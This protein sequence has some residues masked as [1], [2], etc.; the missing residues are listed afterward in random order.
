MRTVSGIVVI[1]SDPP[2]AEVLQKGAV[3]GRTPFTNR[4]DVARQELAVRHSTL[5][6]QSFVVD[7]QENK[8]VTKE[9]RF[10][11]GRVQLTSEPAGA[12]VFVD[13]KK[14]GVTTYDN[15]LV[16]PGKPVTYEVR[17]EKLGKMLS[18]TL[19]L[20]VADGQTLKTNVV[21]TSGTGVVVLTGNLPGAKVHWQAKAG[22]QLLGETGPAPF[23]SK[24]IDKGLQKLV[25][26]HL[27]LGA[28]E[29]AVQVKADA[30][31]PV[32]VVFAYGSVVVRAE[33][34]NVGA[35]VF[36]GDE[37]LGPA[38][39][40]VKMIKAGPVK[41]RVQAEDYAPVLL[42]GEVLAGKTAELVAKL[43]LGQ[44]TLEL[45][46]DMEGAEAFLDNQPIGKLPLKSLVGAGK[47][48]L[49]VK[50]QNGEPRTED[51]RLKR[52]ATE[53]R[54]F[55]FG[56][57]LEV[58]SDVEGAEAFLDGKPLGK[59]PLKQ[60]IVAGAH[61]L[62]VKCQGKEPQKE[63]VKLEPGKVLQREFFFEMLRSSCGMELL[64]VPGVPGAAGGCWVGKYE[65]TQEEY[66]KVMGTNPSPDNAKNPRKPVVRVSHK[67]AVEFCRKL[68][69]KD[70]GKG[71]RY[72]LPT[73][74]QWEYLTADARL[75]D[76]VT[77]W[78]LPQKRE[79]PEVVG[80]T[81]KRNKFGLFDTRGNA[82]EWCD[83][84]SNA[85]KKPL[86]GAGYE[87]LNDKT[88]EKKYQFLRPD[89]AECGSGGFRC[90]ALPAK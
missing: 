28:L 50:C 85:N 21:L 12:E 9:V 64:R 63:P 8:T 44:G 49:V 89:G 4:M 5:G 72:A 3:L 77:S 78:G 25:A 55:R 34:A 69:E 45:T 17:Q 88:L 70:A 65:V 13:G 2:D 81:G 14:A 47:H 30:E 40:Q 75:E 36:A 24:P 38:P 1:Q 15:P 20:Q 90:V 6:E 74:E 82:W 66:E 18:E 59:L 62:E 11:R 71:V 68:T 87:S 84:D 31:T 80:S 73:E 23:K 42:E 61:Q 57:T 19:V 43:Q 46:S 58:K 22:E 7:V 60:V 39:Y 54:E 26:R 48:R 52:G 76:S 51:L 79:Q 83:G 86:R 16:M 27:E 67:D 29:M 37:K 56:A 41:Y 32:N 53:R 35:D 10:P 33:P